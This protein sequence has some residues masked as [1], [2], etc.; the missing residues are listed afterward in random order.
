MI[1]DTVAG[2][3]LWRDR[4]S[5]TGSAIPAGGSIRLFLASSLTRHAA[6][7]SAGYC[8]IIQP[9]SEIHPLC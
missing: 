7:G 6:L 5:A 8:A 4:H 3:V 2:F 9:K 1:R